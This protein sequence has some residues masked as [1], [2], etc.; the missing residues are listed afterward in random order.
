VRILMI[1]ANIQSNVF[2]LKAEVEKGS[3]T[4]EFNYGLVGPKLWGKPI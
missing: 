3:I 1:V 4:M 2:I